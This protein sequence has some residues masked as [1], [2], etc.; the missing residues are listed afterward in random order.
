MTKVRSLDELVDTYLSDDKVCEYDRSVRSFKIRKGAI[1]A[2]VVSSVAA[3]VAIILLIWQRNSYLEVSNSVSDVEAV[4]ASFLNDG[5]DV[6]G[7]SVE[8]M[9]EIEK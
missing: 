9:T 3:C 1:A 6:E 5:P 8:F 4:L 7:A 2:S